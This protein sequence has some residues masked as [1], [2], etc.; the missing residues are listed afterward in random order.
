LAAAVV[1][2][3]TD[4]ILFLVEAELP[5][6][7]LL[8]VVVEAILLV[9]KQGALHNLADLAAAK[10]TTVVAQQEHQV[11]EMMAVLEVALEVRAVAAQE[12][13]V[14]QLVEATVGLEEMV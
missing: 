1:L 11:K 3:Q 8:V 6:L 9:V 10:H 4:Q 5:L 7:L 2:L 12:L 13:Q 14:H